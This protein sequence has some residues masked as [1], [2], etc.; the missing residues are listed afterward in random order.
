MIH[1]A[2]LRK[3]WHWE[4]T[5]YLKAGSETAWYPRLCLRT[6][7]WKTNSHKS[8]VITRMRAYDSG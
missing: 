2:H 3:E 7:C 8:T 5:L 6:M 4:Q 1:D